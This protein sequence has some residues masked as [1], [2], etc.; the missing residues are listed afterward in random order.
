[1]AAGLA[2]IGDPGLV[3]HLDAKVV[4]EVM[5]VMK[6]TIEEILDVMKTAPD[7]IPVVLVGGGSILVDDDIRGAS[8]VT[9]PL[10]AG[11]ANAIGAALSQVGAQVDRVVALEGTTRQEALSAITNEA[12]AKCLNAGAK[13]ETIRVVD[14]DEVPLAYLPSSAVRVTLRVVGNLS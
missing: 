1:V 12:K 7:P 10:H 14:V 2:E 13:E 8:T 6:G 3:S 4:E 11:V 5:A 9:R